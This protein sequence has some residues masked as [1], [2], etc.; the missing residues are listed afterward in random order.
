M[1]G[2]TGLAQ[3]IYKGYSVGKKVCVFGRNPGIL[4]VASNKTGPGDFSEESRC[5]G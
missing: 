3:T 1:I 4:R 5:L 2:C